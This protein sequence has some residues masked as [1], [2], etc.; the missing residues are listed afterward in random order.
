MASSFLAVASYPSLNLVTIRA[1]TT[2]FTIDVSRCVLLKSKILHSLLEITLMH[3]SDN[4]LVQ[5][6]LIRT[7]RSEKYLQLLSQKKKEKKKNILWGEW[8]TRKKERANSLNEKAEVEKGEEKREQ[9][10]GKR[11]MK[12][13]KGKR[14]IRS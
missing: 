4:M 2:S 7:C 13:Q 11:K 14:N 3:N 10:K 9:T 5:R 12:R 6:N 1:A 8:K